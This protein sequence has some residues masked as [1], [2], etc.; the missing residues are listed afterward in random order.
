MSLVLNVT[1]VTQIVMLKDNYHD[2]SEVIVDG[3]RSTTGFN[4]VCI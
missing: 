3:I 1:C 4:G 2:L